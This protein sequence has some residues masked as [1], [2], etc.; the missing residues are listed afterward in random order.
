ME[1]IGVWEGGMSIGDGFVVLL[2]WKS[3]SCLCGE[4]KAALCW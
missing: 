3:R 2:V 1:D 4:G